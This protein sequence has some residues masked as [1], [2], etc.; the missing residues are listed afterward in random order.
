MDLTLPQPGAADHFAIPLAQTMLLSITQYLGNSRLGL[1][2][3]GRLAPAPAGPR[4]PLSC[5]D[6][7]SS[8]KARS[9]SRW[10]KPEA[11][12]SDLQAML[13]PAPVPAVC[14]AQA[15]PASCCWRL[16][17]PGLGPAAAELAEDLGDWIVQLGI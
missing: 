5:R 4:G 13:D 11:L 15:L 8:A 16:L 10:L 17:N 6:G 3:R 2:D 9:L 7:K 1:K 14:Q 12:C